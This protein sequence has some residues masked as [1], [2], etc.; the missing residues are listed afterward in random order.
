MRIVL[1]AQLRIA[2]GA[3]AAT[4]TDTE[5]NTA[6]GVDRTDRRTDEA[7]TRAPRERKGHARWQRWP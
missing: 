2:R 4:D 6:E 3:A 1:Y 7:R 5:A